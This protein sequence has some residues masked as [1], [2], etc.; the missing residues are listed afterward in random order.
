MFVF[1]IMVIAATRPVLQFSQAVVRAI[2]GILPIRP[3]IASFFTVLFVV[4]LLG[5][6]IT[7]PAAMTV[8]AM[9]LSAGTFS[10]GISPRL[11]YAAL[12][13]LF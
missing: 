12:A 11:K 6:F 13:V 1:A 9:I 7:E 2:A 10:R 8:G 5:S 3:Q 4:P